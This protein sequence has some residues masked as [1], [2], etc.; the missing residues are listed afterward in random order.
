MAYLPLS[1]TTM[2]RSMSVILRATPDVC[3]GLITDIRFPGLAA[4]AR[5]REVADCNVRFPTKAEVP[6]GTCWSQIYLK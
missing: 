4:W 5:G 3:Y 6:F 2:P 1:L